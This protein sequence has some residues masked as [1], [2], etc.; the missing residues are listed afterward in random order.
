MKGNNMKKIISFSLVVL[1]ALAFSIT[2]FAEFENTDLAINKALMSYRGFYNSFNTSVKY[3][4]GVTDMKDFNANS[5]AWAPSELWSIDLDS[6]NA[7]A[8]ICLYGGSYGTAGVK[9]NGVFLSTRLISSQY[10]TPEDAMN[11]LEIYVS[12][13]VRTW[14]PVGLAHA[15]YTGPDTGNNVDWLVLWFDATVTTPY[16]AIRTKNAGEPGDSRLG[17]TGSLNNN[18]SYLGGFYDLTEEYVNKDDQTEPA[19]ASSESA[20][21][22]E[23]V[24]DRA[25]EQ[26][27]VDAA[28][29]NNAGLII[30]IVAAV[31]VIA[32]ILAVVLVKKKK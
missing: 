28:S 29:K 23:K 32:A 21:Q 18:Y 1:L 22:T 4:V 10:Y 16:V 14:T 24:T 20:V 12:S 30:G 17:T 19:P 15:E 6:S 3:A 27:P 31:V 5:A 2:A 13:D 25:G 26:N 8:V 11:N 7:V 9:I